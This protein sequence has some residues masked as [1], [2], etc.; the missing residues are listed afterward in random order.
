M[1]HYVVQRNEIYNKHSSSKKKIGIT[2]FAPPATPPLFLRLP[3]PSREHLHDP[4]YPV[5]API[6]S[7]V[8]PLMTAS[9]RQGKCHLAY[10][11]SP[12]SSTPITRIWM[13]RE[14]QPLVLHLGACMYVCMYMCARP[15]HNSTVL[16]TERCSVVQWEAEV[17]CVIGSGKRQAFQ[18]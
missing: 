11:P 7:S 1:R 4:S 5:S 3:L 2:S 17:G 10:Q 13:Y 16:A 14:P 15:L 8:L 9:S 12:S 18:G 6:F